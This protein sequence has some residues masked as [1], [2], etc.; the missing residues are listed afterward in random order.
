MPV[1]YVIEATGQETD[2]SFL[3]E[4]YA[5]QLRLTPHGQPITNEFNMTS[6]KGV[7]TGGDSTN[8]NRDLISAVRDADSAVQGILQ[9]LNV[10]DMVDEDHLPILDRWKKYSSSSAKIAF[11][12][13]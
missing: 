4:E 1:D 5:R 11:M 6:I 8:L 9:Y 10:M 2:Y 7:F 13:R 3:S 12:S